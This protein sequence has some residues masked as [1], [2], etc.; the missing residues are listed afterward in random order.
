M[1]RYVVAFGVNLARFR[2]YKKTESTTESQA[3]RGARSDDEFV[4]NISSVLRANFDASNNGQSDIQNQIIQEFMEQ[5]KRNVELKEETKEIQNTKKDRLR[6]IFA[7][8]G[9]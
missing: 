6:A 4:N 3:M 1:V 7:M 5:Q 8:N 9:N 2:I